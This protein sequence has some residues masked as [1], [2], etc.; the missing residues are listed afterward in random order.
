MS[1]VVS[2]ASYLVLSSNVCTYVSAYLAKI[3]GRSWFYLIE[4]QEVSNTQFA[5]LCLLN[6]LIINIHLQWIYDMNA[7]LSRWELAAIEYELI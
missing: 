7:I 3:T 5:Q 1:D 4:L 6:C 2:N